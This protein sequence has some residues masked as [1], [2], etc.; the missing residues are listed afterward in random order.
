[1]YLQLRNH[2]Y[3]YR[4]RIPKTLQGYF[5]SNFYYKSLQTDNIKIAKASAKKLD[6]IFSDNIV[7]ISFNISPDL[8]ELSVNEPKINKPAKAS[9]ATFWSITNKYLESLDVSKDRYKKVSKY[10]SVISNL[11]LEAVTQDS[12]D[13]LKKKL[14]KLPKGNVQRYK[15]LEAIEQVKLE[16]PEKDKLSVRTKNDYVKVINALCKFACKRNLLEKEYSLKSF[17]ETVFPRDQRQAITRD[18]VKKLIRGARS[19]ELS[20][21]YQN[22][23]QVV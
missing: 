16:V 14:S 10:L 21:V 8:E 19:K 11:V 20:L 13:V 15:E 3:H 12:I 4:R 5:S 9:N 23:T 17:T 2:T 22:S 1:M 7:K 6:V 18:N